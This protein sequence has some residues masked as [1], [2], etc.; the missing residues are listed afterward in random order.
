[1]IKIKGILKKEEVKQF[2]KKDGSRGEIKNFFIEP[3]G[4]IYP[5][6]I[7]T[8]NVDLKIGKEGGVVELGVSVFP[9]YFQDGKKKKALLDYYIPN[10]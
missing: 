7:S 9:Y 1:M 8:T 2:V 4:T 5:I 10:K 3:E 6:K